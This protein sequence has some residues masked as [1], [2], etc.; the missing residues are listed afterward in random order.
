MLAS[1]TYQITNQTFLVLTWMQRGPS[2]LTNATK[3]TVFFY[4]SA[5]NQIG[6]DLR[7]SRRHEAMPIESILDHLNQS[8]STGGASGCYGDHGNTQGSFQNFR[9]DTQP[10]LGGHIHH[11]QGYDHRRR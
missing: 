7:K 5:G 10:F 11:V 2:I 1:F 6:T 9:L 4:D 8:L 3:S